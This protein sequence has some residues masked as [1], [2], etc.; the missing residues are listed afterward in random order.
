[1]SLNINDKKL[2]EKLNECKENG[3]LSQ[4]PK[5]LL[6]NSCTVRVNP[7]DYL[8]T[9]EFIIISPYANLPRNI[10]LYGKGDYD[11][12]NI[13]IN[14][15]FDTF[16]KTIETGVICPEKFKKSDIIYEF[17]LGLTKEFRRSAYN[18]L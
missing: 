4:Y 9:D 5:T 18:R 15:W 10:Y 11:S 7:D 2:I 6:R 14:F 12:D 16:F 1:M 17:T 8:Q 13:Y 3:E